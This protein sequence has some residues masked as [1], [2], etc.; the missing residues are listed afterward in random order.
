MHVVL[1]LL[2]DH[3]VPDSVADVF[4]ARGHIVLLVRN[5]LPAD[6]TDPLV[7]TVSE[8]EGCILVSADRDFKVIAPRIPKGQRQR[9]RKLSRIAIQCSEP[10]AAQRIDEAM[11]LIEA[12]YEIAQKRADKR[13]FVVIQKDGIK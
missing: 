12:E 8:Q 3:N 13:M 2:L 4:R 7:A 11:T 5:I 9:F 6:S 1:R 10:L